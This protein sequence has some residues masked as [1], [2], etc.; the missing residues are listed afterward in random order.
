MLPAA[1]LETV[2]VNVGEGIAAVDVTG[3]V[4]YANRAAVE[5]LGGDDLDIPSWLQRYEIFRED[6]SPLPFDET[7]F[8]RALRSDGPCEGVVRWRG[9]DDG[10]DRWTLVTAQRVSHANGVP[11]VVSVFR[12]VTDRFRRQLAQAVLSRASV[13]LARARDPRM[14]LDELARAIV[15]TLADWCVMHAVGEPPLRI[16]VHV[17]PDRERLARE[18]DVRWPPRT[19]SPYGTLGVVRSGRAQL[20]R[21]ISDEVLAAHA[22]DPEHLTFLRSVGIRSAITV[23]MRGRERIEGA[24]MLVAVRDARAFD[25]EDLAVAQD[26]A[27]RVGAFLETVRLMREAEAAREAA[28]AQSRRLQVIVETSR[29]LAEAGVLYPDRMLATVVRQIGSRIGESCVVRTF[30]ADRSHSVLRAEWYGDPAIEALAQSPALRAAWPA[31]V[32]YFGEALRTGR[33]VVVPHVDRETLLARHRESGLAEAIEPLTPRSL[34][35]IPMRAHGRVIG[36]LALSRYREPRP[37]DEAELA[38]VE[39]LADRAAL[40]LE[41][42]RLYEEAREAEAARAVMLEREREA[43]RAKDELL[44]MLGHELRN[45]LAP[46]LGL[47]ELRRMR[48]A[49]RPDRETD[50]LER[51]VRHLRR[52]VDD[53]LDAAR[54]T[55]GAI[56]LRRERVILRD[57]VQEAAEMTAAQI[58]KRGHRL[59]L[60]VPPDLAVD[61]DPDRLLQI[62]TNL[63]DNAA[64]YTPDNG[65]IDVRASRVNDRVRLSVRDTGRGIPRELLPRMFEVFVQGPRSLARPEAGLGVGLSVVRK[66]VELHG[67]RVEAHSEGVGRGT[68]MVVELPVAAADERSFS[69]HPHA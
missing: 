61:A 68:E 36:A 42:A 9:R 67:G 23:P 47:V 33:R 62:I 24:L 57:V 14:A 58:T 54:V 50:I 37:Y 27:D 8:R 20:V 17:D 38:L 29:I 2:L 51:Q 32:G 48:L 66:L 3:R 13:S 18:L 6:G 28:E 49:G 52:L 40:T 21:A 65:R 60:D 10:L 1:L 26:L 15:P 30:T 5:V 64:K 34:A 31:D 35:V 11:L 59:E 43:N 39:E 22:Q 53:L 19:E 12:D 63:L 45:P 46:L 7:P 55:R 25:D 16:L 41:N 44:A 69:A 4:L 56:E